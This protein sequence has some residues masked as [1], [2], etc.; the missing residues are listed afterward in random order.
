MRR[1]NLEGLRAGLCARAGE[2]ALNDLS[3]EDNLPVPVASR[4]VPGDPIRKRVSEI[5]TLNQTGARLVSQSPRLMP[6]PKLAAR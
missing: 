5:M 6:L 2:T 1:G 4:T 3:V